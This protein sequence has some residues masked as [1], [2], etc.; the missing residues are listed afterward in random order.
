MIVLGHVKEATLRRSIKRRS[1]DYS[2]LYTRDDRLA[3][4]LLRFNRTWE[5][6]ITEVPYYADLFQRGKVPSR[7]DSWQDFIRYMPV[8][9]REKVQRLT[10]EMTNTSRKADHLRITGGT[11]SQPVR[12]P[13]WSS[14]SKETDPDL[15]MARLWYGIRPSSRSFMIWGDRSRLDGSVRARAIATSKKLKNRSLGCYR[16]PAYDLNDERMRQ[17]ALRMLSHKPDYIYAYSMALDYFAR[18]NMGMASELRKLGLKAIIGSAEAFQNENTTHLLA[19]IFDCPIIM[20]YGTVESGALAYSPPDA[21]YYIFWQNY[22]IEVSEAHHEDHITRITTLY[23]RCFPLIRYEIGD[24][25]DLYPGDERFGLWRFRKVKGKRSFTVLLE[26]GTKIHHFAIAHC[27]SNVPGVSAWQV[28]QT[29]D[30]TRLL[31]VMDDG[32]PRQIERTIRERMSRLHPELY[33]MDIRRVDRL[34]Q[35]AAGKTP[36][37]FNHDRAR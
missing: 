37:I 30:D 16:F 4:Q 9:T 11:T 13:S 5:R 2:R 1:E 17:A 7:F 34:E 20:E 14:E 23:P 8:A 33:S 27:I 19:D 22:F 6:T 32:N 3:F 25:L 18:V 21:G 36:V 31:L 10:G 28:V 12:L 35:T 15:W 24:E 26:D 29:P